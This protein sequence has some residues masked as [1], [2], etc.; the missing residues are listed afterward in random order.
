MPFDNSPIKTP[1]I[2]VADIELINFLIKCRQRINHGWCQGTLYRRNFFGRLQVCIIGA[3]DYIGDDA[4]E[5]RMAA[6]AAIA[7]TLGGG[8]LV[9]YNNEKGRTKRQILDLLDETIQ[10]ECLSSAERS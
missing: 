9:R 5:I 10:R 8:N 1:E 2:P 6:R 7:Q 4:S 3:I